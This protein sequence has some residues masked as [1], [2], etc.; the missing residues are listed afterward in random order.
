MCKHS[1]MLF[2]FTLLNWRDKIYAAMNKIRI[3]LV[4]VIAA[5]VNWLCLD[6]TCAT[7]ASE[8]YFEKSLDARLPEYERL[9]YNVKWLGL[10]V[11]NIWA[12]I[13]GIEKIRGRDAYVLEVVVKTNRFCSAIYKIEDR[14]VSY[15]DAE[16]LWCLYRP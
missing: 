10:P 1:I 7:F 5:C 3:F 4:M 16:Y 14:Y 9:T 12:S 11:G 6:Q 2:L 13:K 8:V 15:L